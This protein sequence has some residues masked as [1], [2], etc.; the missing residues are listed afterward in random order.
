MED[1]QRYSRVDCILV[2]ANVHVERVMVLYQVAIRLQLARCM[3]WHDHAPVSC[4]CWHGSWHDDAESLPPACASRENMDAL[5]RDPAL[6][7]TF[8]ERVQAHRNRFRAELDEA[9]EGRQ[10]DVQWICCRVCSPKP[11]WMFDHN[12]IDM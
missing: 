8:G 11:S 7:Q 9:Y 3:P 1:L 6:T 12:C 2:S 5:R 4:I 10:I